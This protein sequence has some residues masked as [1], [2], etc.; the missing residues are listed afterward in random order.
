M[1]IIKK[2]SNELLKYNILEFIQI[3]LQSDFVKNGYS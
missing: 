3:L 2:K 1:I